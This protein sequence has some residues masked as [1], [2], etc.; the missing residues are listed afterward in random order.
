MRCWC[1]APKSGRGEAGICENKGVVVKTD[2]SRDRAMKNRS[3]FNT[4][5]IKILMI[6][7]GNRKYGKG[8][9][10]NEPNLRGY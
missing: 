1:K 10:E 2:C 9:K 3:K 4:V 7:E 6:R 8:E 5:G